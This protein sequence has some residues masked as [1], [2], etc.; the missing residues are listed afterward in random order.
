GTPPRRVAL[1][2]AAADPTRAARAR[3]LLAAADP[4]DRRAARDDLV[5][6]RRRPRHLRGHLLD[7]RIEFSRPAFRRRRGAVRPRDPGLHPRPD[8]RVPW[9][10]PAGRRRTSVVRRR[11]GA[12]ARRALLLRSWLW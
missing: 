7:R 10:H 8:R 12:M 3:G 9:P 1:L 4:V 5:A 6:A 11:Q 2:A